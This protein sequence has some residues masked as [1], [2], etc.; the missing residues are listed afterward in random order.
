[1]HSAQCTVH[2]LHSTV[3]EE[4]TWQSTTVHYSQLHCKLG[5]CTNDNNWESISS[6]ILPL[7]YTLMT[8]LCP[9][10]S[11]LQSTGYTLHTTEYTL[12]TTEYRVHSTHYRVQ[13]TL[14]CRIQN[15]TEQQSTAHYSTV[16]HSRTH[17]RT[18]QH[19]TVQNSTAQYSTEKYSAV[20]CG[21]VQ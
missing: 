9:L 7:T 5:Q 17:Y 12:H 11:T 19:G 10:H 3:N 14:C 16:Q 18:V 15:S 20:Q 8:S 2:T 1:M 4:D 21:T 6:Y 13:S